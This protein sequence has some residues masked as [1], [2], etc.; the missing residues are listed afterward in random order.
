M[1]DEHDLELPNCIQIG[2][3]P[4]IPSSELRKSLS[5]Y[6][7]HHQEK[8]NK[9]AGF[10]QEFTL[11]SRSKCS[12]KTSL[13]SFKEFCNKKSEKM[14]NIPKVCAKYG[15]QRRRFY[16]I[17]NV[18]DVIGVA[19]KI[20]A[21]YFYW[22]GI[23][24]SLIMKTLIDICNSPEFK[25]FDPRRSI[26]DILGPSGYSSKSESP[27]PEEDKT[28]VGIVNITKHFLVSFTALNTKT[29]DV[30]ELSY[31]LTQKNKERQKTM[32][33]KLYLVGNIL[34]SVGILYKKG[35]VTSEFSFVSEYFVDIKSIIWPPAENMNDSISSLAMNRFD[36]IKDPCCI[37][38]LLHHCPLSSQLPFL[39]Q[40]NHDYHQMHLSW[41]SKEASEE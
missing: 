21:D 41:L 38:S 8:H 26:I 39:V 17:I 4:S 13:I 18:L 25:V 30:K 6:G 34:E 10:H 20:N 15:F 2:N 1:I 37:L 14:I 5:A 31:I 9:S 33:C 19:H 29:I 12:F 36:D 35:D 28:I 7:K 40:R 32:L 11:H 27:T 16:D 24:T 23:S 22:N 3:K